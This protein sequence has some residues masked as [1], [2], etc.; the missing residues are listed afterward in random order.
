MD[1]FRG[2]AL[3]NHEMVDAVMKEEWE[4]FTGKQSDMPIFGAHSKV[5]IVI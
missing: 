4:S 2:M 1:R 3:E 5:R